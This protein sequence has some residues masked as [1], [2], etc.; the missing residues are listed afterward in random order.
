MR[1]L[2]ASLRPTKFQLRTPWCLV[3]V[4]AVVQPNIPVTVFGMLSSSV[5]LCVSVCSLYKAVISR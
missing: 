5:D 4:I 2:H 1:Y 3:T